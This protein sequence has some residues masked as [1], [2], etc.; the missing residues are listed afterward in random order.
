MECT[1]A[2]TNGIKVLVSRRACTQSSSIASMGPRQ[3]A[4]SSA[5]RRIWRPTAASSSSS[6]R[7]MLA[8]GTICC[9]RS[10][11]YEIVSWSDAVPTMDDGGDVPRSEEHTSELQYL[12][13]IS[14]ADFCFKYKN[15]IHSH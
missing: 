11:R 5:P 8:T 4:R 15:H 13:R 12:M 10:V 2:G 7:P 9:A 3:R 1:F 14:Y 6:H